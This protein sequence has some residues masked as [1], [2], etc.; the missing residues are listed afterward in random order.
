MMKLKVLFLGQEFISMPQRRKL[1]WFIGVIFMI[2]CLISV[3]LYLDRTL[4]WQT[5]S[6]VSSELILSHLL[7][8]E[9][10]LISQKSSNAY[11][12]H[13]TTADFFL[14]SAGTR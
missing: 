13:S 8:D 9:G 6:D 4:E 7:A 14:K 11:S 12:N 10:G 3:E 2:A 5:D 1:F